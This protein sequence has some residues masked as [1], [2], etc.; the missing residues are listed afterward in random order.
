MNEVWNNLIINKNLKGS[1]MLSNIIHVGDK[2]SFVE[3]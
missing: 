2:N 1:L 3:F